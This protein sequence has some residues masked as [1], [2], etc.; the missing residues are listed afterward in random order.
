MYK[1]N[2]IFYS[3]QGEGFHTG[4]PAVFVRFAG[5][6]LACPWC[7]TEYHDY[8]AMTDEDIIATV[9]TLVTS[10]TDCLAVKPIIVLTGGEPAIQLDK[11][12]IDL[13]HEHGYIVCVETNGTM[14]LP[15]NID[16]ITCS[17]KD[18]SHL[19]L[20]HVD[21]LKVVYTGKDPEA[22][23]NK[24]SADHLFIQPLATPEGDNREEVVRYALLHPRWRVSMQVH[25]LLGIK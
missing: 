23:L 7:D 24:L 20:T 15:D 21:E 22:W 12:F 16:W 3:L 4:T 11:R 8:T 1:V 9:N 25:K 5:C 17:P 13:L 10:Q 14:P 18:V 6:N 19:T 2:E